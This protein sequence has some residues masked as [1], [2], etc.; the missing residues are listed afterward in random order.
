MVKSYNPEDFT[1]RDS[2]D[3]RKKRKREV[4]IE[5]TD[6]KEY[7]KIWDVNP[8][9]KDIHRNLSLAKTLS[10]LILILFV[11]ISCYLLS[12]LLI[13]SII[14]GISCTIGF[15][16]FFHDHIY[17]LHYVIPFTFRSK[18]RFNPFEDL[19]F[20][21]EKDDASTLY[22]SNRKD[23]V[24]IAL[25]IF[26]VDIIPENVSSAVHKFIRT[27]NTKNTHLSYSYQIVQKPIISL[28]KEQRSRDTM[29][30]SL[31]SR[32]TSIYFTVF[33]H[34]KG[35][36][37]N[38]KINR[39]KYYIKKDSND[40]KSNLVSNFHHFR[41]TLL[42]DTA[43]LNALRTIF[44]KHDASIDTKSAKKETLKGNN[45]HTIGK[46]SS[47]IILILYIDVVLILL[48]TF[49]LYIVII[50]FTIVFFLIF[51]WW[52]SVLFQS[53]KTKLIRNNNVIT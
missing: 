19:V 36:L 3:Q 51:I 10:L 37:S 16:I 39:L 43:L 27:L 52:R 42:S 23:L 28:F 15:I 40:L 25:R 48:R 45:Y 44:T 32:V 35:I 49:I 21:H 31:Q 8:S 14:L 9:F 13:P 20:W 4:Y 7:L 18:L 6:E 47:C 38:H 22:I 26:Q 53:T 30:Q 5:E 33:D 41:A 2:F 17:F 50:N 46:L 12:E 29:L 1:E 11:I 34:V 24:H